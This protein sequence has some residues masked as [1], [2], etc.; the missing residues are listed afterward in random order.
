M[1]LSVVL[2]NLFKFGIQ[3]LLFMGFWL[4]F[5]LNDVDIYIR[6]EVAILPLLILMIAGLGLGLGMLIS[7]MTTK[8]RDLK[9]LIQ[10]GIQ[11]AM[12]TT[13]VIYPLAT[14]PE[15][16][17]MFILIN[18][19]TAIIEAFRHIFLGAGSVS[20]PNL[21][22]SFCSMLII[23]FIGLLVFQRTEKTFMDTI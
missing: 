6:K 7:S 16:Y 22:Y 13:P 5:F 18:P 8:Y 17:R 19:M 9:F 20:T 21:M 4:F 2:S 23:F 12:Y 10:F 1:P 3:F 15:N 14:A 11:L